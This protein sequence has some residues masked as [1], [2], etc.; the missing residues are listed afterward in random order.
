M[1]PP[2]ILAYTPSGPICAPT[3]RIFGPFDPLPSTPWQPAQVP[4]KSSLPAATLS[5]VA[6]GCGECGGAA[7]FA[8]G[9]AGIAVSA[10]SAKMNAAVRV[11]RFV[12]IPI[13]P[14][15]LTCFDAGT[16]LPLPRKFSR[17]L[18]SSLYGRLKTKRV[19]PAE[20]TTYCFP[21]T[22][23]DTGFDRTADP[24][25]RCHSGSPVSAFSAKKFPAASAEKTNPPA[26]AS[27]P[28]QESPTILYSHFFSP[29]VASS[30]RIEVVV[31]SAGPGRIPPPP[32]PTTPFELFFSNF[33]SPFT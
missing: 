1:A 30:A 8:C 4:A 25:S 29:V 28:V 33:R 6:F 9:F 20:S 16:I 10:D 14:D 23:Y 12:V 27:V 31:S 18:G 32:P 15:A 24:S 11:Q 3:P 22:A 19:F 13:P 7:G 2:R 21:S 26:V 5:E 17:V